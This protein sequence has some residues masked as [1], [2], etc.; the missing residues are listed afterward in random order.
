MKRHIALAIHT[1][2]PEAV[3][4]ACAFVRGVAGHGIVCWVREPSYDDVRAVVGEIDDLRGFE[5]FPDVELELVV[6]FGGDGTILRA[7]EWAVPR[8]YPVLG[9]NL[10]HVGFLAELEPSEIDI[11]TS[12]VIDREYSVEERL[13]LE[14][15]LRERPGGDELWTSFA[16]NE[17]SLEKASRERM[18]EVQVDIDGHPLSR[19]GTDGVLV[20]TPTGSTAYA[21]SAQGPV[22]WPDLDALL[23]VPLLAHALFARPLVLSPRSV[24]TVTMLDQPLT[25]G[26]L[27]CDGRRS[28]D[29]PPGSEITVRRS[30]K[31]LRLARTTEQPFVQRL[32]A[33]FDLPI[34]GWR[35]TSE[36]R[37]RTESRAH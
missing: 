1:G 13:C 16:V 19:W 20:S 14:V 30:A 26:V 28:I 4:A 18:I 15:T 36:D 37:A 32:V 31:S 12:R 25:G 22:M 5:E 8:G 6:V 7:A 9:V 33:K 34:R 27:W 2:R 3:D 10:G 17:V 23:V 11:L 24:V 35:G 29:A 21:F